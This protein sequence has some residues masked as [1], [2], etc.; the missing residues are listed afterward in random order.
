LF[1][2]VARDPVGLR[3][4]AFRAGLRGAG[5]RAAVR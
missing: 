2:G 4:A 5:L 3:G 1:T